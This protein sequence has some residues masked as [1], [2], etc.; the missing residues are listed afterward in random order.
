MAGKAVSD[1][2]PILHLT[3]IDFIKA[4][5][6]FSSVLIPKEVEKEIR[7]HNVKLPSKIK[8]KKIIPKFKDKIKIIAN[9]YNL[10]LGEAESI[11]LCFQE[12][13]DYFITDDLEARQTAKVF[14]INVRGTVGIVL[15]SFREKLINKKSAIKKIK[16]LKDKSSLFITQELIDEVV[17]AIKNF[18]R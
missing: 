16:E 14:N 13:A 2:G 18:K 4:L 10:D 17:E 1:T 7:K 8:M 6:I 15:K 9:Q 11:S 5:N 3:E 12:K